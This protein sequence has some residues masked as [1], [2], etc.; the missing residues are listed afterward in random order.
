V[1]S[2]VGTASLRTLA[3]PK[4]VT[5][6][7]IPNVARSHPHAQRASAERATNRPVL[8]WLNTLHEPPTL[9]TEQ[10]EESVW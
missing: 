8:R 4:P 3:R 2:C 9:L 6:G 1:L 7:P 5:L 10:V